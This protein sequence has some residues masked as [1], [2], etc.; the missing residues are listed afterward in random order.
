MDFF[1]AESSCYS[2]GATLFVPNTAE[3]WNAI[4]KFSTPHF[5][6]WIGLMQDDNMKTAK[7]QS[8]G[9]IEIS[10]LKWLE[11]SYRSR[12]NGWTPSS[13]CVA[14]FNTQPSIYSY[15]YFYSCDLQFAS[16]CE[17]NNTLVRSN[18]SVG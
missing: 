1:S 6:T 3:E 7:W 14:N 15:V 4:M 2:Q 10:K 11:R 9:G 8:R 18:S 16:I 5:W 13:H 12:S 17:R